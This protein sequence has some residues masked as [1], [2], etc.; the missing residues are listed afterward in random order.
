MQQ[1]SRCLCRG[2]WLFFCIIRLQARAERRYVVWIRRLLHMIHTYSSATRAPLMFGRPNYHRL[3]DLESRRQVPG[4]LF[5]LWN[6]II[7]HAIYVHVQYIQEPKPASQ[8]KGQSFFV[9]RNPSLSSQTN[10]YVF[11]SH[12]KALITSFYG[13]RKNMT[14]SLWKS[15]SQLLQAQYIPYPDMLLLSLHWSETHEE[16]RTIWSNLNRRVLSQPAPSPLFDHWIQWSLKARQQRVRRDDFLR[17]P[18]L[19]HPTSPVH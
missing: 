14:L 3:L 4:A 17:H 1:F 18:L 6:E 5:G 9:T 8:K 15:P 11:W 13:K 19:G 2:K 10:L 12:A 16:K 7:V